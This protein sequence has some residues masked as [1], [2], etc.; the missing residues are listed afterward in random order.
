[1]PVTFS[2][3]VAVAVA[4]QVNVNVNVD[5]GLIALVR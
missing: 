1:L 5:P 4:V 3:H 2:G